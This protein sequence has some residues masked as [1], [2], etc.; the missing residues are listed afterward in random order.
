MKFFRFTVPK[1]FIKKR[2]SASLNLG[3]EISR[4][5]RG[6]GI[7]IFRQIYF[8]HSGK[9]IRRGNLARF[10]KFLGVGGVSRVSIRIFFCRRVPKNLKAEPFCAVPQKFSG[11]DKVY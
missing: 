6:A 2:F 5:K 3:I 1:N 4:D 8:S 10:R 11:S 7:T 9:K